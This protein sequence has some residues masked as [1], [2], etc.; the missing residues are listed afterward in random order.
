MS[1]T[2]FSSGVIVTSQ[3]L[4]GAQQI[5]FDGQDLDWHYDPLGLSSLITAGPDGIDS[6]Y[7]TLGSNQP[8]MSV[9]GLYVSGNPIS[10]GKVVTGYWNFGYDPVIVENPANDITTAPKSYTT[11]EKYQYASGIPTPTL[12]QKLQA[13]DDADLITKEILQEQLDRIQALLYVD[14][15]VYYSTTDP[16]CYNYSV[17][18]GSDQVCPL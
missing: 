8:T 6:R 1:K 17:T 12:P 10:G 7:I 11:N 15:G 2:T 14:D 9:S 3:W 5:Y 16:G 4:N 13:M 18:G